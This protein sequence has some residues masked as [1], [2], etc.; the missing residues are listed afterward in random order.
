MGEYR[1]NKIEDH[2]PDKRTKQRAGSAHQHGGEHL[3]RETEYKRIA[4]DETV[5]VREEHAA[6]PS[7]CRTQNEADHLP[8]I[9]IDP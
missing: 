9:D 7:T 2:A 6:K 5:L 4:I 8:R 3:Y 1:R